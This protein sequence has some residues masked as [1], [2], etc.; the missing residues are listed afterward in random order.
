MFLLTDG[1]IDRQT[2]D[3]KTIYMSYMYY[4][5]NKVYF[6]TSNSIFDYNIYKF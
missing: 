5:E 1:Q 3:K 4:R 2:N 6:F